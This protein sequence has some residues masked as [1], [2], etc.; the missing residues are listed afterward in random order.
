MT[1]RSPLDETKRE[2]EEAEGAKPKGGGQRYLAKVV[3]T[4]VSTS[5]NE[6]LVGTK[7][8]IVDKL[9]ERQESLG[10]T[11]TAVDTV[12]AGAGETV[13]VC[14]GRAARQVIDIQTA[15]VDTAI[16]GTVAAAEVG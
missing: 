5:K 4:V 1:D 10:E 13:N 8:L 7:L 11:N 2:I 15:P 14:V 12:G 9:N 6:K 16:V 3:G